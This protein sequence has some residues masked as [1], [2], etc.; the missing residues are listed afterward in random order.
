MGPHRSVLKSLWNDHLDN[1]KDQKT[2]LTYSI[3][4]SQALIK[5]VYKTKAF[6]NV[7]KNR[8]KTVKCHGCGHKELKVT[9]VLEKLC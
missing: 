4:L 5:S 8:S 1:R 3:A 9:N 2:M 6:K 7:W